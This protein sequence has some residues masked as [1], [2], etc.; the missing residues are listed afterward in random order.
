M[1]TEQNDGT[2]PAGLDPATVLNLCGSL[3]FL[4]I[5]IINLINPCSIKVHRGN[6]GSLFCGP[7]NYA[8]STLRVNSKRHTITFLGSFDLF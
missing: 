7:E 2:F 8:T 1:F 6:K 4:I 3:F 5:K